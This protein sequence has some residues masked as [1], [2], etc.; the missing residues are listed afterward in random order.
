MFCNLC[1]NQRILFTIIMIDHIK[2]H[3]KLS[4]ENDSFHIFYVCH[5]HFFYILSANF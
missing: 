5:E 4:I 1:L 2:L 3:I